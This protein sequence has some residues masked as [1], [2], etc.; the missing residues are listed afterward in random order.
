MTGWEPDLGPCKP[1][2]RDNKLYGRGGADDGYAAF[3][4][5]LSVKAA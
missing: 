2:V 1:V 5:V 4:A 3:C